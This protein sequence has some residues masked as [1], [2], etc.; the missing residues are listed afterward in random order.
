MKEIP[1]LSS[2]DHPV[3][4]SGAI[5]LTVSYPPGA[6]LY[7][8]RT[9]RV[10]VDGKP[11][12]LPGWGAHRIE[13]PAGRHKLQVWVPYFLPRKTGRAQL[14]VTLA[15]GEEVRLEYM[16][17]SVSFARGSLGAPG[18]QKS[19]GYSTVMLF[20]VLAVAVAIVG[21]IVMLVR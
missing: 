10:Q 9:P 19:T 13:V 3:A 15:P 20:N 14:D 17:P 5:N 2:E 11:T 16:A 4:E 21:L 18:E 12:V 1:K 7:S 6:F 8:S